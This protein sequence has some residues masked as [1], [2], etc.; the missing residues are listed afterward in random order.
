MNLNLKNFKDY[1]NDGVIKVNKV[2]SKKEIS[3]LKKKI[4]LYIKRNSSKLKGKDINYINNQVNS[5][6]LFTE[7]F[8]KTS[9][10][11]RQG[12][13]QEAKILITTNL[14]SMKL[15]ILSLLSRLLILRLGNFF[16][17]K[18]ELNGSNSFLNLIL[19]YKKTE[20]IK[21]IIKGKNLSS[22]IM[23]NL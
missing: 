3:L 7:K 15:F 23:E 13:H 12:A 1:S 22:F 9:C 2:F 10:S 17:T 5:I 20:K 18:A 11:I 16:S 21:K 8:F 6:H 14:L 19:L 4:N